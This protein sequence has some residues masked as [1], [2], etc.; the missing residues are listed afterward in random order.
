LRC[1]AIGGSGPSPKLCPLQ[2]ERLPILCHG[3]DI[4]GHALDACSTFKPTPNSKLQYGDWL[5][6]IPPKKQEQNTR[7]KG[8][9]R[10]LD[11]ARSSKPK[12][13][14]NGKLSSSPISFDAVQ[15]SKT[16]ADVESTNAPTNQVAAT[17]PMA[18]VIGTPFL[19]ATDPLGTI[20]A[21]EPK[22]AAATAPIAPIVA[23][24]NAPQVVGMI[25]SKDC[26]LVVDSDS[27]NAPTTPVDVNINVPVVAIFEPQSTEPFGS[28]MAPTTNS[29]GG[30]EGFIDFFANPIETPTEVPYL[31]DNMSLDD[32]TTTI[33]P[34]PWEEGLENDMGK[35]FLA[36]SSILFMFDDWLSKKS[37]SHTATID[38]GIP[39]VNGRG[40]KRR[41]SMQNDNKLKKPRPPPIVSKTRAGISNVK[42]SPAK[43][44]S[45]P[46]R[47]K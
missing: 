5:R 45:Q 7:S 32:V 34:I 23:V 41:S 47:G 3:C 42:N 40:A 12:T 2:Y 33:L 18:A 15:L 13:T 1:V 24:T 25:P 27:T 38:K 20:T 26:L 10:Y 43:V 31:L 29:F 22:L 44:D 17:V 30:P 19:A 21:M 36:T 37:S 46:R 4:I 39:L 14:T 16:V 6:Y 9:I 8:S 11:G 35:S 28:T